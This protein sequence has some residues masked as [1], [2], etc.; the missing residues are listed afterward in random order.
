MGADVNEAIV[1]RFLARI[2]GDRSWDDWII[3]EFSRR[4]IA[5]TSPQPRGR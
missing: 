4:P 3:E 5:G 2:R 1:R